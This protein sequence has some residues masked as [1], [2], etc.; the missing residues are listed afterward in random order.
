ML[1]PVDRAPA[2]AKHCARPSPIPP[3]PPVINATRFFKLKIVI[4]SFPRLQ[5]RISRCLFS[6][7]ISDNDLR[8]ASVPRI[9]AITLIT[10]ARGIAAAARFQPMHRKSPLD[11]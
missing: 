1:S 3:F 2:E 4:A 10:P 8:E 9:T 11:G 7:H 6:L 5:Y